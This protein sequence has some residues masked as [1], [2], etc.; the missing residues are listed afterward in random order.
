MHWSCSPVL[1]FGQYRPAAIITL[2]CNTHCCE[3][4]AQALVMWWAS[5]HFPML[6]LYLA[7]NSVANLAVFPWIWACFLWICRFFWRLAGC[8]FLGLF[9]LK[10]AS[11]LGLFFADFCIADCFFIKFHGHLALSISAFSIF[12]PHD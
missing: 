10:F 11:F 8:L 9:W 12:R 3:T 7:R 5:D 4:L 1:R 6:P 2:W